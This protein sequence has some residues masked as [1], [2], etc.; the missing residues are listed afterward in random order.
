MSEP[1]TTNWYKTLADNANSLCEEFG[2]SDT[3]TNRL[4][5]FVVTVAKNQY[6]IGNKSGAAWAFKQ[7]R[8][9]TAEH[10]PARVSV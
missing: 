9:G 10:S 3:Q 2:L 8:E 4:R 7:A 6:R 1:Q 5:D